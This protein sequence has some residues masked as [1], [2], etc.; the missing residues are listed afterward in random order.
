[1]ATIAR[2]IV[3]IVLPTTGF[4][5]LGIGATV[6]VLGTTAT[7]FA[8]LSEVTFNAMHSSHSRAFLARLSTYVISFLISSKTDNNSEYSNSYKIVIKF[9]G[10]SLFSSHFY[11]LQVLLTNY[12][13]V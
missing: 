2:E 7:G 13:F 8:S 1:M 12:F 10:F 3:R 6:T 4:L 9:L 11:V 5:L